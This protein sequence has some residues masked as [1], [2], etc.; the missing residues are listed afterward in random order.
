MGWLLTAVDLPERSERIRENLRRIGLHAE[1]R[2]NGLEELADWWEGD[3]VDRI[4]LD[5]PCS[6]TGVIR[7][8]PDIR[9]RRLAGDL[10]RFAD[11]QGRLLDTAWPLLAPAGKLLYVTCS[12]LP[13]ENDGVVGAF[14]A[15]HDSAKAEIPGEIP[16]M[17][18]R[19]GIQRLPGVHSG[20]GFYYCRLGKL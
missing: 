3:P 12:I 20:D 18:T 17:P 9:H 19:Y 7:R 15:R 11:Q 6:G 4:L 1:V 2:D 13:G 10:E 14:L 16:G 8:H 5:A